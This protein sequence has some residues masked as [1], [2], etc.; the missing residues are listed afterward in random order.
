MMPGVSLVWLVEW[1]FLE[2]SLKERIEANMPDSLER[3]V[4]H[5]VPLRNIFT[6]AGWNGIENYG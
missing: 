6:S 2:P 1:D 5:E 4:V 3:R